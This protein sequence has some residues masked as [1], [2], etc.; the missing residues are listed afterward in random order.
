MS[1]GSISQMYSQPRQDLFSLASA[2][3]SGNASA[4]QTALTTFQQ[5]LAGFQTATGSSGLPA[6]LNADLQ[7]LRSDLSS[8]NLT[9]AKADFDNFMKDLQTKGQIHHHHHHFQGAGSLNNTTGTTINI[10]A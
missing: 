4:A 6:S 1:T 7:Q 9:N 2:L 5:D 3:N 8:N 10:T